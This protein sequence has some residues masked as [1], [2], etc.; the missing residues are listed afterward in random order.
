MGEGFAE[1]VETIHPD[2]KAVV[3][4]GWLVAL[5]F[6]DDLFLISGS[7]E[8]MQILIDAVTA[9]HDFQGSRLVAHKSYAGA[10]I[11]REA[12]SIVITVGTASSS[13]VFQGV[14][15][16]FAQHRSRLQAHKFKQTSS[17][18]IIKVSNADLQHLGDTVM[19]R[20]C[21]KGSACTNAS[22]SG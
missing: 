16:W 20:Q 9:Y 22:E 5:L 19:R 14:R 4:D 21:S 7:E 1:H 11:L 8:D 13:M 10:S 6:C 18:I 2:L 15:D 3:L 12:P 17:S